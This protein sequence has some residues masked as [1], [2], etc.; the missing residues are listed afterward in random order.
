MAERN[1]IKIICSSIAGII[2]TS[3]FSALIW[4]WYF[5]IFP[6]SYS[7]GGF[8]PITFSSKENAILGTILMTVLGLA[9]GLIIGLIIS[10]ASL[11]SVKSSLTGA[12]ISFLVPTLIIFAM[13]L[14]NVNRGVGGSIEKF[15]IF[16]FSLIIPQ[17]IIGGLSGFV[18]SIF[19][20]K[21]EIYRKANIL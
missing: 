11:S 4:Y 14:D 8:I 7:S 3:F 13:A 1:A 10:I 17:F 15:W 21:L 12:I 2:I 19:L 16:V 6:P 20:K 9:I 18:I 5:L